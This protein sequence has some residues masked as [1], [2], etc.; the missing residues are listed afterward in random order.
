MRRL[1]LE[2]ESERPPETAPASPPE[3]GSRP[4]DVLDYAQTAEKVAV[5]ARDVNGLLGQAERTLDSPALKKSVV[6]VEALGARAADE[7]KSVLNHAFL[8]GA[9]LIV[10]VLGCALAYNR[11]APRLK[12]SA[13]QHRREPE[14]RS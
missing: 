8:L 10:L 9:G 12:S 2:P 3:P 7:A 4:F 14:L 6:E 13:R 1:G 11:L 5:M